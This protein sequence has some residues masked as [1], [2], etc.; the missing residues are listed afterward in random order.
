MYLQDTTL[1]H[2]RLNLEGIVDAV[3]QICQGDHH[4]QLNN[5]ILGIILSHIRQNVSVD[6]RSPTGYNVSKANGDFFFFVKGLTA[7]IK[8][9]PLYLFI[10]NA[11]LL[12]RSSVEEGSIAAIIYAGSFQIGQLFIPGFNFAL[13]HDRIVKRK[14]G[15]QGG[16]KSGDHPENI[17]YL[18]DF[19]LN[20]V[21]D[22][23]QL[24]RRF[25]FGQGCWNFH[26]YSPFLVRVKRNPFITCRSAAPPSARSRA[27]FEV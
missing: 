7:L 16:W 17:G 14:E 22:S 18:A 1:P 25:F 2:I 8:L 9:Q 20:L 19:L 10:G 4:R 6:G 21:I 13:V 24:G 15:F 3:D 12:R 23:M 5:F 26:W 11:N 27:S